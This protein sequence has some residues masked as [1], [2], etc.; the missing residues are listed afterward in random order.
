MQLRLDEL[1]ASCRLIEIE[2]ARHGFQLMVGEPVAR[3][4]S[5]DVVGFLKEVW[6][7]RR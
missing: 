7:R 6:E 5:P 4:L 2:G 3:D 1:G